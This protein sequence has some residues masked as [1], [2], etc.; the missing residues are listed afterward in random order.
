MNLEKSFLWF[1]I[2]YPVVSYFIRTTK[3]TDQNFPFFYHMPVSYIHVVYI[4]TKWPIRL[5]LI[6]V[7]LA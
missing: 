4:Q 2:S 1:H 6:P 7:S 5:E 3:G